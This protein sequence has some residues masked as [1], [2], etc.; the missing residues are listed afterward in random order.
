MNAVLSCIVNQHDL[1]LVALAGAICLLSV[2]ATLAAYRRGLSAVE[3]Y[4]TA[5]ETTAAVLGG[6]GVW[7]THFLGMLAYRPG[8]LVRFEP[9][10][11]FASLLIAVGGFALAYTVHM[12]GAARV[13]RIGAGV[14]VGLAIAGMH[15]TGMAALE[16]AADLTWRYDLVAVA[17]ACSVAFGVA[18]LAMIG[19][20]LPLR[21]WT[22]A[23]ALLVAAILSLHFIGMGAVR[24]EVN[25]L[26]RIGHR[27][28]APGELALMVAAADL[29]MLSV[30][31]SVLVMENLGSRSTL[32]A[33][34]NALDSAPSAIAFFDASKRLVFW[35]EGFAEALRVLQITPRRNIGFASVQAALL[36]APWLPDHVRRGALPAPSNGQAPHQ[37]YEA[38]QTPDGRWLQIAT[39]GTRDGGVVVVVN[40]ITDERRARELADQA[41]RSKSDFLANVSHEIRTP[42]NGVI[43]MAQV[44]ALH[45]L[46]REQRERLDMIRASGEGL[47]GVLNS[48]LDMAKI[49]AGRMELEEHPTQIAPVIRAACDQFAILASRKGVDFAFSISDAASASWWNIDGARLGQVLAN[50]ASNAVKFTDEG[51]ILVA[52]E[53][54]EQGLAFEVSDT[55]IGVAAAD[56]GR[57]F[58][59]FSQADGSAARRHGGT[60]LG[61]AISAQLVE[62]MG[63]RL[64]V[65]SGPQAGTRFSFEIPTTALARPHR[66]PALYG[67][68]P[69]EQV[70]QA[71]AV[72][73][74][75]VDDN[76]TNRR[77]IAAM[78]EALGMA[79]E[80]AED[81]PEA[82]ASAATHDFDVVLMDIQMPGMSGVEA[83][84]RIVRERAA[85]GRPP[86]PIVAL[87]ANVMTHQVQDYLAA[88]MCGVIAKPIELKQLISAIET[89]L[90]PDQPAASAAA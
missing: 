22:A 8:P 69:V 50:L 38:L 82:V 81:G 79:V 74:L 56:V 30:A 49:E 16:I 3:P 63:G 88:G 84:R 21:R 52:C 89:A 67:P 15:F 43:G 20:D 58:E 9:L 18:A 4:R 73:V 23:A 6:V 66:E 71:Q 77:V 75:A 72:T 19:P 29:L 90:D 47:L 87:T 60:G 26:A 78:L 36:G 42:L 10:L 76:E 57:L 64:D 28:F 44:M 34:S 51:R 86:V 24:L 41:N 12:R 83:A 7:S 37:S 2:C 11:T 39:G 5:W 48:V 70:P 14:M 13:A 61:L 40:D 68:S 27:D 85:S 53:R 17:V 54:T 59:K 80:L 45:P 55:G 25:P 31:M 62:L 32:A 35:N 46:E 65:A 1:R 33:L